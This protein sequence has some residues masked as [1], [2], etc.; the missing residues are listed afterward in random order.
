MRVDVP[1]RPDDKVRVR[2][3]VEVGGTESAS[4]EPESV[5]DTGTVGLVSTGPTLGARALLCD[6]GLLM[7]TQIKQR[8]RTKT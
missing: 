3:G 6:F 7:F 5:P 1:S 4:V 2:K 8:E